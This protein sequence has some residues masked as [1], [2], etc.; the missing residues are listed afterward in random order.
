M[1]LNYIQ[2]IRISFAI[3]M[4]IGICLIRFFE[5]IYQL[6]AV[7]LSAPINFKMYNSDVGQTVFYAIK[8]YFVDN[9][10]LSCK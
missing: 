8:M 3:N 6:I 1:V 4:A 7:G 9:K 2:I 5:N 10:R